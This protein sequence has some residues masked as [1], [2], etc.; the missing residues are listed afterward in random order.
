M[1][2]ISLKAIIQFYKDKINS[3][4]DW[5]YTKQASVSQRKNYE[6]MREAL[7]ILQSFE[8]F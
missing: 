1:P 8:Q 2:R 5:I 6:E 4:D 3:M 7:K